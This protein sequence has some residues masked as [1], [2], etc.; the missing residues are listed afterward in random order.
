[1]VLSI[2]PA[3]LYGYLQFLALA[4]LIGLALVVD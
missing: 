1:L 4:V 3:V 2:T